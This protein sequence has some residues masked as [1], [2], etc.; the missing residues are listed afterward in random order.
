MNQDPFSGGN[1]SLVSA[2]TL[3]MIVNSLIEPLG[4]KV[5]VVVLSFTVV[6]FGC[7]FGFG[8]LRAKA[9]W[10]NEGKNKE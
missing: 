3:G 8:Y 6:V 1:M 10:G 4:F 9:Y 7:N 5:L 2:H